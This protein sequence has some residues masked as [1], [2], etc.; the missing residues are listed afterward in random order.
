MFGT[1]SGFSR[2]RVV[3]GFLAALLL[4]LPAWSTLPITQLNLNRWQRLRN[5]GRIA[6]DSDFDKAFRQLRSFI[7]QSGLIGYRNAGPADD[8]R[9]LY[10]LQYSLAPRLIVESSEFE[11]VIEGGPVGSATSLTHDAR[12]QIVAEPFEQL[13]IFRKVVRQ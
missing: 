12:F 4:I 1:G 13:R 5:A 10:F 8:H 6:P 3:L 9:L 7:P 11:F 2:V